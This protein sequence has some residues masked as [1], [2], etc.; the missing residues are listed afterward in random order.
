MKSDIKNIDQNT[1]H[2]FSPMRKG[3]RRG[4]LRRGRGVVDGGSGD[5]GGGYQVLSNKEI[6]RK[7][8]REEMDVV[9]GNQEHEYG[10]WHTVL[11]TKYLI[12]FV[13]GMIE[14]PVG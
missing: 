9:V 11:K 2:V 12:C 1:A 14:A 10:M 4:G 3:E 13:W 7:A 6:R 5:I 8:W